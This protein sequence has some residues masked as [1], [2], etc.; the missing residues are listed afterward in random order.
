MAG[1]ERSNSASGVRHTARPTATA[2]R[3]FLTPPPQGSPKRSSEKPAR[4]RATGRSSSRKTRPPGTR[5]TPPARLPHERHA[6]DLG[7]RTPG[8]SRPGGA[9]ANEPRGK[10]APNEAP[11]TRP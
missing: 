9:E 10:I 8:D 6:L 1:N 11:P 4:Q 5:L 2:G 7:T 3:R